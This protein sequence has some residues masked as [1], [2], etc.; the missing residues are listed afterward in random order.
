MYVTAKTPREFCRL[1]QIN[2]NQW[3]A[4]HTS[5][6]VVIDT[7]EQQWTEERT[8]L[9]ALTQAGWDLVAI[10]PPGK[11]MPGRVYVRYLPEETATK[12]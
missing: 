3:R 1:E 4:Y 12:A 7:A 5:Q 8:A 6:G 2:D 11:S 9:H 10:T